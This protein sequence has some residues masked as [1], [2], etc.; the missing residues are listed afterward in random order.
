MSFF[1][2]EAM[3]YYE[4]RVSYESAWTV[5]GSLG[6]LSS[7]QIED[8][9]THVAAQNK[10]FHLY[11]KRCLAMLD[12]IS[13]LNL[14]VEESNL[15]LLK[16]DDYV[17]FAESV[18]DSLVISKKTGD[19]YLDELEIDL[20]NKYSALKRNTS[21]LDQL[22]NKHFDLV[23]QKNVFQIIRPELPQSIR[24]WVNAASETSIEGEETAAVLWY[25]CGVMNAIDFGKFQRLVYRISRGNCFL[26]N[27]TIPIEYDTDRKPINCEVTEQGEPIQRNII[28]MT[29]P[30]GTSGSLRKKIVALC[31]AFSVRKYGLPPN[32]DNFENDINSLDNEIL[33]ILS[34][35]EKT[36]S[37]LDGLLK[38]LCEPNDNKPLSLLEEI[39]MK[40]LRE[41]CIYEN[42]DRMKL[43]DRIFYGRVWIPVSME[44]AVRRAIAALGNATNISPPE[45]E[46]KDWNKLGKKPPTFFKTNDFTKVYLEIVET[47]GVPRY[48]EMNPAP[49][50][51]ATFPYQFG[52][53][54]GDVGHGGLLF[55]ATSFLVYKADELREKKLVPKKLLEIRYLF[56]LMGCFALYC[57]I[58]YNEFFA[59]TLKWFSSCYNWHNLEREEHQ[60]VYPIGLDPAWYSAKNE[61]SYFNSFKMK[62]SIIIGVIHMMLGIFMRGLNNLYF[63]SAIDFFCEFVPQVIFLSCTFGYMCICIFIKWGTDWSDRT[64]PSILNIYT[65]MGITVK[66]IYQDS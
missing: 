30:K 4:M 31:D 18:R 62:L 45:L 63:R 15:K 53:M 38:Q 13:Y 48:Q 43:K 23:E 5:F 19:A 40:V 33:S 61:V 65:G 36:K 44:P 20:N 52:V 2:S 16:S 26:K 56:F 7:I 10:H 22:K 35:K 46:L 66:I 11:L 27:Y 51:I 47:Y 41:K 29:F 42:F 58:I 34:V 60:C 21:T 55:I 37:E 32:F 17:R 1:R 59:I 6:I 25:L 64:P 54:F 39:K 14:L 9:N 28:F 12:Q 8:R 49:W 24:G 3:N 50:S 57:G